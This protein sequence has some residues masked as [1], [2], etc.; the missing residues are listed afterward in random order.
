MTRLNL[1]DSAGV[2]TDD[3][4]VLTNI[5]GTVTI[6]NSAI[7][8]SP[9]NGITV[10]NNNTNMAAF[11]LTN[12]LVSCASGQPCQPS[13]SIGN[14]GL[15]LVMRGTSV[16]TKG[17]VSGSTFSGHRA[18]GVQI[19][20]NDTARIG[21]NSGV[22]ATFV[23]DANNSFVIQSNTFTGNGQGIDVATSQVSNMTFQILTNTVT[24]IDT[25]G[26]GNGSATAINVFTA[27]GADTGPAA[28]SFVGK[29]DGNIIGTQ[30]VKDSGSG[31]GNGIRVV[32]Q[33]QNTRG[34]VTVNNNTVRE[35]AI[36]TP[37]N[38]YGQNGAAAAGTLTARFKITNNTAPLP[39]GTN[40]DV[41]GVN[42]PC[43]DAV[44]FILADEGNPVCNVITGNN[45]FDATAMN[46]AADIYLAERVGPPVGAQLTVEGTGGSNSTYLQANNTLAGASK[47][48]DEGANTSQVAGGSCG[49]FP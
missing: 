22:P 12:S 23:L 45:L 7:L 29:I 32:V 14:D 5:T 30:G 49:T 8:N 20:T 18:L 38:F 31:F 6:D 15:L 11:N 40:V 27:A 44:L 46:G 35:T 34:V 37:L 1:T 25:S 39:S 19:Q 3:G 4:M 41:C 2:A 24:G 48:L 13:G 47:F 9:H 36:A 10:D 43:I 17:L 28:H 16:L 42:T 21:V 33:G 26:G